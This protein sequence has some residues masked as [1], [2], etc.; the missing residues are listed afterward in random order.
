ASGGK[1]I[2]TY[3]NEWESFGRVVVLPFFAAA[4]GVIAY[5]ASVYTLSISNAENFPYP[6]EIGAQYIIFA[7]ISGLLCAVLGVY[8]Q[9]FINKRMIDRTRVLG[10]EEVRVR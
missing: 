2:D 8:L 3:M 7:T 9:S 6:P 5:G 1:I 10:K 4:I